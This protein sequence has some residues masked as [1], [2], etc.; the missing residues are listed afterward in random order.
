MYYTQKYILTKE[1][2][3]SS[4][5]S[6]TME[7]QVSLFDLKIKHFLKNIQCK[8]LVYQL[9]VKRNAIFLA[10]NLKGSN[11]DLNPL[12]VSVCLK[13]P[14]GNTCRETHF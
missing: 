11:D 8:D 13:G 10:S 3:V 12:F 5:T 6:E 9:K 4:K 2:R 7:G 14:T 1:T